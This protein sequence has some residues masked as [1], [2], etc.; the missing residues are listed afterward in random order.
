MG[1]SKRELWE[2][3]VETQKGRQRLTPHIQL[4]VIEGDASL[5]ESF[6]DIPP[7]ILLPHP[8]QPQDGTLGAGGERRHRLLTC[9][10]TPT[11]GL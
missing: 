5:A 2:R 6:T 11:S 7:C 1:S 9:P 3:A 8:L 4:G 10:E